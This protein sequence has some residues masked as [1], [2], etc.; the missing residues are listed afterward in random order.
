MIIPVGI[1]ERRFGVVKLGYGVLAIRKSLFKPLRF[2]FLVCQRIY[3][4]RIVIFQQAKVNMTIP[5]RILFQ[6]I[7]MIFFSRVKIGKRQNLGDNR[8]IVLLLRLLE[9][10][11]NNR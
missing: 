6:I 4:N 5:F 9:D 11:T 1:A 7:L 8:A 10:R 3:G 2:G